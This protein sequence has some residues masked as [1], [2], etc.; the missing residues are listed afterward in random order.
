MRDG[1]LVIQTRGH[2][3]KPVLIRTNPW[4]YVQTRGHTYLCGH[5][6]EGPGGVEEHALHAAVV[7]AERVLRL[8]LRQLMNQDSGRD[9]C[10]AVKG[11]TF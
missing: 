5:K 11:A 4:L 10:T 9:R 1:D 6:E 2:T 7:L 8:L 3:Y